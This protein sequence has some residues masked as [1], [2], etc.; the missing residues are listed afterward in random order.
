V[1]ALSDTTVAGLCRLTIRAPEKRF[2]LAVPADVP[3]ADLMPTVLGYAGAELDEKGLEH[4]GWAL[5]RL[6]EAPLDQEGTP[7][8]LSLR[9]GETIYLRPHR[10]ALPA[11]HF[12]DLVDGVG[13]GLRER[14][15]TWRP[16]LTRLLLL[17]LMSTAL[18]V[19]LVMLAAPGAH[20]TRLVAAA[21]TALLLL[22]GAATASRAV[23][24]AGAGTVLG[25]AAVPYL[26]LAGSLVPSGGDGL[27]MLG[28]SLLAGCA[29]G[30]GAAVLGLA[31]VA[32]SAP[33]FLGTA[34][35][36]V[37]G[38]LGGAVVMFGVPFA[39]AA[40]VLAVVTVLL[41]SFIPA[42]A[43][44]LSGLR[45]PLLP[46][47]AEQLQE[48]IEPYPSDGVI[49]RSEISNAYMTGLYMASGAVCLVCVVTLVFS[50]GWAVYTLAGALSLLLLIHCLT[51]GSVWHRLAV[52]VPGA[53]GAV[54][55]VLRLFALNPASRIFLLVGVLVL[56]T[57]LAIASWTV[58]GRRLLPYWGRLVDLLH[59]FL[60]ISLLPLAAL[61]LG[62]YQALRGMNG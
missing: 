3:L 10:D 33:F 4:G 22:A 13:T 37:L 41:G 50:S 27:T 30:A 7:D 2:E 43:F 17:C 59:L 14:G 20:L 6:G 36:A 62:V 5:Q 61:V 57:V 51:V 58:P 42:L 29:A 48:D 53:A 52:V 38:G 35:A 47:N 28:A 34:S 44:R 56:A 21:A 23:G 25:A 40:G 1:P 55:L 32:D 18:L 19:G 9:D 26:A 39:H 54:L 11:I 8:S 31:F 15:D 45:L 12:D 16:E 49:A 24:D 60:A 46:A